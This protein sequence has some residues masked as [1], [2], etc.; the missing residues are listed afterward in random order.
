MAAQCQLAGIA[1]STVHVDKAAV[2]G[3]ERVLPGLLDEEYA[4]HLFYGSQTPNTV[5]LS[6]RTIVSS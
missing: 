1:Q 3:N 6:N 4:R 2:D 5:D